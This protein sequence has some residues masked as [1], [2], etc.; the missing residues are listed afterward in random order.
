LRRKLFLSIFVSRNQLI[1]KMPVD[2]EKL[3]NLYTYLID[4]HEE[5]KKD[6]NK[7]SEVADTT[8][9]IRG[10][11]MHAII[12]Y[13]RWF[14]ATSGK[15]TLSSNNFFASNSKEIL[16]HNKIVELRDFIYSL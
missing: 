8:F 2:N 15:T 4:F 16:V 11:A 5:I 14:K 10:A 7:L 6:K 3:L 13:S 12:L 1:I 9:L